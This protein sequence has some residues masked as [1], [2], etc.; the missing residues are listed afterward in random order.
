[1]VRNI[2][3]TL[4]AVG[5]GKI[6]PESIPSLLLDRN[7]QLVPGSAPPHGLFLVDV[8]YNKEDLHV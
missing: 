3:S 8:A 6:L 5:H 4:V 1:M 2:V 7:R